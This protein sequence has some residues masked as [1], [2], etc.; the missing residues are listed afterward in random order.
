M[1]PTGDN[2]ISTGTNL[3]YFILGTVP[4]FSHVFSRQRRVHDVLLPVYRD[5]DPHCNK[6]LDP[7]LHCNKQL[8]PDP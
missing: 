1:S 7:D 8:H 4:T 2:Y 3:F 5:P 6:M